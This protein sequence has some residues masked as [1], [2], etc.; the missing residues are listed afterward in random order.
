MAQPAPAGYAAECYWP[1]VTQADLTE[2]L[3]RAEA[4]A[5]E[6]RR[7]GR[8]VALRGAILLATDET[9]FCLFNGQEA[10][11]RAAS[12]LAGVPFERILETHWFQPRAGVDAEGG[13]R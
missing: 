2:T 7:N 11:V 12:E 3:D 8:D 13:Q 1:G 5:V 9:V 4:A 10:D 6:L